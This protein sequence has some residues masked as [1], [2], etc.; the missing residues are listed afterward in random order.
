MRCHDASIPVQCQGQASAGA[1]GDRKGRAYDMMFDQVVAA[2][3]VA[4]IFIAPLVA[5]RDRRARA[6]ASTRRPGIDDRDQRPWLVPSADR[7]TVPAQTNDPGPTA[8]VVSCSRRRGRPRR[9][10]LGGAQLRLHG[11][12]A[13]LVVGQAPRRSRRRRASGASASRRPSPGSSTPRRLPR[14]AMI[15]AAFIAP[16]PGQGEQAALEVRAVGRVGPDRAA[17]LP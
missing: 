1:I 16:M 13:G 17:S 5:L 2:L 4:A 7:S 15:A 12:L 6:T 11:A 9:S 3:A 8:G 14:M 10:A